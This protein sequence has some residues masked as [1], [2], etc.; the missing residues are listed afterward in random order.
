[1]NSKI[2]FLAILFSLLLVPTIANTGSNSGDVSDE[3]STGSSEGSSGD[4]TLP[5]PGTLTLLLSG[6]VGLSGYYLVGKKK[7]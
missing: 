6:L 1:M 3:S 2:L 5:E 4:Q 7:K